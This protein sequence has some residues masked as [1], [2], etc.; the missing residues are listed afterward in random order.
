MTQINSYMKHWLKCRFN[1][2][3]CYTKDDIYL[4][5]YKIKCGQ[6]LSKE[7]ATAFTKFIRG[8]YLGIFSRLT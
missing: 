3:V 7:Q 8:A 4:T 5:V 1:E 6:N 2:E